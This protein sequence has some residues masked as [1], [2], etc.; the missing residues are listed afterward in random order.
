MHEPDIIIPS[1]SEHPTGSSCLY[2]SKLKVYLSSKTFITRS[3]FED[4]FENAVIPYLC[5]IRAKYR[6]PN[7]EA[8][9]I[10]ASIQDP[11]I[12][13]CTE[14]NVITLPFFNFIHYTCISCYRSS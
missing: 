1:E 12:A 4:S 2:Y 6:N 5:N 3:I 8:I 10:Y 13:Y 9:M 7:V 14:Q 11:Y